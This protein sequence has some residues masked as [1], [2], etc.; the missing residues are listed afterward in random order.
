MLLECE[1]FVLECETQNCKER[2]SSLLLGFVM[3]LLIY[4]LGHVFCN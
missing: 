2:N 1:T 4:I 3:I